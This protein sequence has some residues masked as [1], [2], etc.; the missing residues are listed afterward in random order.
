M[1]RSDLAPTALTAF[2]AGLPRKV[3][4]DK[5]AA[6]GYF[7]ALLKSTGNGAQSARRS[8]PTPEVSS[9]PT[10][11]QVVG[12]RSLAGLAVGALCSY[13]IFLVP[14]FPC[15]LVSHPFPQKARNG[16]A[17]LV[18]GELSFDVSQVYK[19]GY[20]DGTSEQLGKGERNSCRGPQGL[21]PKC[22]AY[23]SRRTEC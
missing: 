21:K 23:G 6:E 17:P 9:P 15:I 11:S 2:T 22:F 4:G 10:A 13:C 3:S 14:G 5:T 18:N 7:A 8:W 16:W 12:C 1:S 19:T 20:P